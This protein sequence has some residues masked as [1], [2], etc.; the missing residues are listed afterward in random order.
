MERV[1]V[2]PT[3]SGFEGADHRVRCRAVVLRGVLVRRIVAATDGAAFEA[4]PEVDPRVSGG[5]TLLAA[6][7]R[8]RTVVSGSTQV[9]AEL[10]GHPSI[11]RLTGSGRRGLGHWWVG[12]VDTR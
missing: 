7:R 6:V 2:P 12:Y 3:L 4:E 5:E 11:V 1:A 9:R 8:V 10:L